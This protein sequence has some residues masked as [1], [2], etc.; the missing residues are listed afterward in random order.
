MSEQ[1]EREQARQKRPLGA[2]LNENHQRTITVV[3][4]RLENWRYN[5]LSRQSNPCA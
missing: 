1:N 4:R 2:L 3:L 5:L